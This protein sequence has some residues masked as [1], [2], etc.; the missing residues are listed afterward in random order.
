MDRL[1]LEDSFNSKRARGV[2]ATLPGGK[3]VTLR[4]E[5]EVIL[6][7]GS[8]GT[9]QLLML[10]GIGPKNHLNESGIENVLD[11]LV[12]ENL[13]D[14]LVWFGI[15]LEFINETI[16]PNPSPTWFLDEAYKYLVH[17][18]GEFT[19]VG[20]IDLTGFVNLKDP[21]SKY[22]DIQFL[23]FYIPRGQIFNNTELLKAFSM[24]EE[25]VDTW[26]KLTMEKDA[27]FMG[28]T[29]LRPRSIGDLKLRSTNPEDQLKIRANY[30][31]DKEDVEAFM[32][33][34]DFVKGFVE[35]ETFKKLEIKL[36]NVP[37][38]GCEGLKFDTREYWECNVRHN[39]G[40]MYHPVGTAKMG[41]DGDP[42]AVV[43]ER[44]RVRG[45]EGLRVIDA[46][47]MPIIVSGN[48]NSL[49][50]MIAEKGSD[51]IKE[52]RKEKDEL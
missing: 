51:M 4:A 48:T 49:T 15:Q 30:L 2:I 1:V 36:R 47:I 14:H 46:S 8:I 31:E 20:G 13:Q 50:M 11:L 35:T 26:S 7:A 22:P 33:S 44:L 43:D 40:T 32:R 12:G 38:P 27:I 28:P 3:P 25:I 39:A 41:P 10:S 21:E 42:G 6:S 9:P 52:D 17:K 24:N 16:R 19:S 29:V 37:I 34:L 45:I 5:K 23:H 18:T